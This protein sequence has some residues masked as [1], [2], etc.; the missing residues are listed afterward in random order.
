M[1]H[2]KHTARMLALILALVMVC[3]P[4]VPIA[5][6][7]GTAQVI[8]LSCSAIAVSGTSDKPYARLNVDNSDIPGGWTIGWANKIPVTNGAFQI[9]IPFSAPVP[10]GTHLYVV[11]DDVGTDPQDWSR[12]A[13]TRL[14][15]NCLTPAPTP[16]TGT[17]VYFR[18]SPNPVAPTGTVTLTWQVRGA[19]HVQ[20][21][22][23]DRSQRDVVRERLPVSGS[24]AVPLSGVLTGPGKAYFS[25]VAMNTA[26]QPLLEAGKDLVIAQE[27]SVDVAT[28]LRIVSFTGGPDSVRRGGTVTLS[29]DVVGAHSVLIVRCS[30]V[31]NI[32][33]DTIAGSLPAKGSIQYTIP[34]YYVN[35]IPFLLIARDAYGVERVLNIAIK[36]ACPY[37]RTLIGG[38]PVTQQQM[39]AAYQPFAGGFM[40]WRGDTREIYVLYK[41][42]AWEKLPDTWQEGETLSIT[43]TPPAGWTLPA[44]GFGKVWATQP[45]VREKLGWALGGETGYT[46]LFEI[47]RA[48]FGRYPY[49]F[50]IF[51]LPDSRIVSLQSPTSRSWKIVGQ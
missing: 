50:P 17:I 25:L 24:L 14:T 43:E 48:N 15:T 11:V 2:V 1:K 29:W 45:G 49:D 16:G 7:R 30:E 35:S 12:L 39:Q 33:Q 13:E 19:D 51:N 26:H 40:F 27:I 31:G 38:C 5:R 3:A 20:I 28:S 4:H 42:G 47:H 8:E 44:R 36:I 22:W 21:R 41:S 9:T 46:A 18:A 32:F 34:D 6:A 37:A 23:S 10:S